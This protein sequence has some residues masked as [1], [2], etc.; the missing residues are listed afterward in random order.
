MKNFLVK[1]DSDEGKYIKFTSDLF[2]CGTIWNK[3]PRGVYITCLT[4][5]RECFFEALK[6]MFDEIERLHLKFRYTAPQ[7]PVELFLI[8]RGYVRYVDAPG[9]PE[10]CNCAISPSCVLA[11]RTEEEIEALDRMI[12]ESGFS[13]VP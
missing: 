4:P 11:P 6:A 10:Y 1:I 13:A 3:L 12:L 7:P 9:T 5:R 2:E 8:K